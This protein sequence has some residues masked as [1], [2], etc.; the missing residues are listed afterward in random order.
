MSTISRPKTMIKVI[1]KMDLNKIFQYLFRE[2]IRRQIAI[3]Y[4][5]NIATSTPCFKDLQSFKA[6][7]IEPPLLV[8]AKFL[9][10][11]GKPFVM[12]LITV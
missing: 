5:K 6:T 4:V 3:P 9:S 10:S 1:S 2:N 8:L 7:V 11:L 12:A